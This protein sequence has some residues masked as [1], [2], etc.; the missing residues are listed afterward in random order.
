MKLGD[1]RELTANLSD[2]VR[3]YAQVKHG[4]SIFSHADIEINNAPSLGD[5]MIDEPPYSILVR[6]KRKDLSHDA[7]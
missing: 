2:D 1:F 5:D 7:R 3:I 4:T 6:N